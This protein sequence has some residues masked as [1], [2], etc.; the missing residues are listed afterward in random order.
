[1]GRISTL[2]RECIRSIHILYYTY[3]EI[4]D[5][6]DITTIN[7]LSFPFFPLSLGSGI[8]A[9]LLFLF[10]FPSYPYFCFLFLLE[11]IVKDKLQQSL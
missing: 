4:R 7:I 8:I 1:M 11:Y 9:N 2:F 3:T 10:L 6:K 5:K